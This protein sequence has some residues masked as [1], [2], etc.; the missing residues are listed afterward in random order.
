MRPLL[1]V[2][3]PR[4]LGGQTCDRRLVSQT[5]GFARY[6]RCQLSPTRNAFLPVGL[7]SQS[8]RE[9]AVATTT[10]MPNQLVSET[11]EVLYS[12]PYAKTLEETLGDFRI[13]VEHAAGL[14]QRVP[15]H[16]VLVAEIEAVL[17]DPRIVKS[18]QFSVLGDQARRA[19]GGEG[20]CRPVSRSCRRVGLI[21]GTRSARDAASSSHYCPIS[22]L[23]RIR[24]RSR[25]SRASCVRSKTVCC[26][27]GCSFASNRC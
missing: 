2:D 6:E 18:E 23:K 24:Y 3:R 7:R 17:T 11:G 9:I 25:I 1:A 12:N 15:V 4:A 14:S 13:H 21:A 19:G 27:A 20:Q 26:F 5:A 22:A 10:P 8:R 16:R